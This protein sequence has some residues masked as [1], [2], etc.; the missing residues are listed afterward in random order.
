MADGSSRALPPVEAYTA[1]GASR[2]IITTK[3][4]EICEDLFKLG[5]VLFCGGVLSSRVLT[6]S[7]Q[8]PEVS[9]EMIISYDRSRNIPTSLSLKYL[10]TSHRLTCSIAN[11]HRL[12][13]KLMVGLMA[14]SREVEGPSREM[15]VVHLIL[16]VLWRSL[17]VHISVLR[18]RVTSV[19]LR[20]D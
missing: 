14:T 7:F 16:W 1:R 9:S 2:S 8:L 10:Q 3:N 5:F 6:R 18:V 11:V 4:T 12:T 19:P 13:G 17:L 20:L 15:P